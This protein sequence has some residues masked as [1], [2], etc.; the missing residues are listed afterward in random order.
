[1][2]KEI[3]ESR[4]LQKIPKAEN[5]SSDDEII[6]KLTKE[7][8]KLEDKDTEFEEYGFYPGELKEDLKRV[9][10][11]LSGL[12]NESVD[13]NH[14]KKKIKRVF[15]LK[16]KGDHEEAV[17][18]LHELVL[19][20]EVIKDIDDILSSVGEIRDIESANEKKKELG[21]KIKEVGKKCKTGDYL[22][23]LNKAEEIKEIKRKDTERKEKKFENK[24]NRARKKLRISRF[25]NANLQ[26]I[27]VPV[28]TGVEAAKRGKIDKAIE[29]LDKG[30]DKLDDL[31]SFSIKLE[32]AKSILKR[33]DISENEAKEYRRRLK[34]LRNLGQGGDFKRASSKISKLLS[35]ISPNIEK[36]EG[37]EDE[38][39]D[40]EDSMKTFSVV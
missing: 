2:K 17:N 28:K 37:D 6:E 5:M 21:A 35:E 40:K 13:V 9:R 11:V 32:R 4:N 30:L 25:S 16:E 10:K 20:V 39:K 3:K 36:E 29:H 38:E 18:L 12:E 7:I 19:D 26:K 22:G 31:F 27:K 33:R 1:M 14:I 24:L 23:A 8:K 15:S 34:N